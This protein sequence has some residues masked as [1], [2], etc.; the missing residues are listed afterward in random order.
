MTCQRSECGS[1]RILTIRALAADAH[2]YEFKD[3]IDADDMY[4]VIFS[5][6]G[7][8]TEITLCLECGQIQDD[9]PYPQTHFEGA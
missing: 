8:T 4:A 6:D 2:S 7:K 9:F 1:N 5:S 3:I